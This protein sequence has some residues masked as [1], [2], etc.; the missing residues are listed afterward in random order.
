MTMLTDIQENIFQHQ[1]FPKEIIFL[2][3]NFNNFLHVFDCWLLS[4][5]TCMMYETHNTFI[6]FY[7]VLTSQF[8]LAMH[9]LHNKVLSSHDLG[10]HQLCHIEDLQNFP[11]RYKYELYSPKSAVASIP[12]ECFTSSNF[13]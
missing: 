11:Y 1:V 2:H 12:P 4:F 6:G 3:Y 8:H 7:P 9:N 10:F 5:Y 13:A